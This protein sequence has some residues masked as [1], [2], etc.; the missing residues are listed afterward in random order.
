MVDVS[1][2]FLVLINTTKEYLRL[3]FVRKMKKSYKDKLKLEEKEKYIQKDKFPIIF[4][5]K[6]SDMINVNFIVINVFKRFL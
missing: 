5:L 2:K 4:F 3:L 6:H 1:T